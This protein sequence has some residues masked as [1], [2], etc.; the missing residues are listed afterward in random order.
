M[1]QLQSF[2]ACGILMGFMLCQRLLTAH[3]FF[4]LIC[5]CYAVCVTYLVV[6]L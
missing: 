5:V 1:C 4:L 6:I 3:A 2:V